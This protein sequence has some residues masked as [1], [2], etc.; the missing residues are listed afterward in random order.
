MAEAKSAILTFHCGRGGECNF[1][2]SLWR[3]V[4]F[5]YFTGLVKDVAGELESKYKIKTKVVVVD[6]TEAQTVYDKVLD[7]IKVGWSFRAS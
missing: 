7:G 6:F 5:Q 2:I 4:I 1:N 3:R